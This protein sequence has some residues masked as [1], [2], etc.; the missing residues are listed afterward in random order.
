MTEYESETET[1]SWDEV[2]KEIVLMGNLIKRLPSE[3]RSGA[4]LRFCFEAVNQGAYNTFEALGILEATK[5]EYSRISREAE[6]EG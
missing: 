5:E 2:E 1:V 3:L 4:A 6:E